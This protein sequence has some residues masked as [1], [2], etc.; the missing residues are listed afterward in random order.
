[1]VVQ[2]SLRTITILACLLARLIICMPIVGLANIYCISLHHCRIILCCVLTNVYNI[3]V[4][5][6]RLTSLGYI[7][8]VE[9][10]IQVWDEVAEKGGISSKMVALEHHLCTFAATQATL[11]CHKG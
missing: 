7:H 10:K 4:G 1:M 5:L 6:L 8:V 9:K 2:Q 11:Y 3:S